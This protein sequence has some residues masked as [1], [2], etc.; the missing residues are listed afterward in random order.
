MP[1]LINTVLRL[2]I[3]PRQ[4]EFEIDSSYIHQIKSEFKIYIVITLNRKDQ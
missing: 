1:N 4:Q 3:S 2:K